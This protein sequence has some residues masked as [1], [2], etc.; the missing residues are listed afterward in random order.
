MP[1]LHPPEL[2]PD[3]EAAALEVA[4]AGIGEALRRGRAGLAAPPGGWPG[5][6]ARPGAAFVTLT[7][8][9][10]L[11][12][13]VGTLEAAEPLGRCI[14]RHALAAAFADPRLPPVTVAA[15]E[16]MDVTVSVLSELV[17][18]VVADL[19]DLE[20]RLAPGH[21]G[22]VVRAGPA[23]ATFLPSVWEQLPDPA[24]FRRALWAKAG[25]S[26]AHHPPDLRC[27]RYRTRTFTDHGPRRLAAAA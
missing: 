18:F 17:P 9:G 15:Y 14:A 27:A 16:A 19:D 11:L 12:G 26:P 23:A 2:S 24:G 1:T 6:L 21:D 13:C 25:W 8:G 10:R 5:R 20:R 7:H 4:V 22:V 3:E